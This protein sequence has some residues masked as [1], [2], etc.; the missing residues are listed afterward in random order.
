[1]M[2][3]NTVLGVWGAMGDRGKA[4]SSDLGSWKAASKL[5]RWVGVRQGDGF[6]YREKTPGLFKGL[7]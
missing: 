1:M 5:K 2:S 3:E 6:S 4:W 7:K